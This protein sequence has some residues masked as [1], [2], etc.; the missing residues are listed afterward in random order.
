MSSREEAKRRGTL[1]KQLREAHAESVARAQELLK[2]QKATRR[3]I[4]RLV[5]DNAKTVP[6]IAAAT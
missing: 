6:E 5:R 2:T 4:C 1:L 3:E